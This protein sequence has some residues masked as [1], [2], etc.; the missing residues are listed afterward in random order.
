MEILASRVSV[1]EIE[2]DLKEWEY[3][4]TDQVKGFYEALSNAI[5]SLKD[6][7]CMPGYPG[8]F[9]SE[10]RKGT[11]FAHVIEHV[12]LELIHLADRGRQVYTGWTRKRGDGDAYVIHYSAPD[13]LTGRL[14]AILA[15][16]LVKRLLRSEDV[17]V[18]H[19]VGALKEPLQYFTQSAMPLADLAEPAGIIQGLENTESLSF[20]PRPGLSED[21]LSNI[22]LV[23]I[24]IE[25]HL[26][27]IIDLWKQSFVEYSG[28]FGKAIIDKIELINL[29][30]FM[31]LLVEGKFE[32]CL[33]GIGNISQIIAAYRIPVNFVVHSLWLYKNR[34]LSH[35]IQEY[36]GDKESLHRTIRDFEDFFQVILAEVS[37]G[38]ARQGRL[39]GVRYLSE[40][41]EFRE[42]K[43]S[44]ASILVVDDDE[45]VR[46]ASRDLLEFHG[47]HAIPAKDGRDALEVFARRQDEISLVI[48]DLV[49]PGMGGMELYPRIRALE[50]NIKIV[51]LS[52]YPLDQETEELLSRESLAFIR[53]PFESEILLNTIQ[54]LLDEEADLQREHPPAEEIMPS[55]FGIEGSR[56]NTA[57]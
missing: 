41:K 24:R 54:L 3:T 44:K 26:K 16:D 20:A 56:R 55:V 30:K 32:S 8:G 37:E 50:P 31:P 40:L 38:F 42:L 10:L 46:R 36:D 22:R 27:Y 21:Q 25:K 49:M 28:N 12:I 7:K 29:D 2:L 11:N 4:R 53:K 18:E 39:G 1:Y 6:H 23:L 33:R 57:A 14:A 45:M 52:G 34:L 13:F 15:V 47:Y 19:Y 48:I 5:V 43:G 51:L 17:D 9:F 35:I